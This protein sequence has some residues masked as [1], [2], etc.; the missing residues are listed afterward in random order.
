MDATML[1]AALEGGFGDV[2]A[3]LAERFWATGRGLDNLEDAIKAASEPLLLP[4][5]AMVDAVSTSTL[6]DWLE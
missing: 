4:M 2:A 3:R 5:S 6:P 1:K